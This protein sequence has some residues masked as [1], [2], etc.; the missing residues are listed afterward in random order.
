ML[1]L[2]HVGRFSPGGSTRHVHGQ[3]K[4]HDW[5][6]LGAPA[7]ADSTYIA[8]TSAIVSVNILVA[9]AD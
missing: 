4:N 8:K 2:Q 6:K 5:G 7:R 9:I 1:L 3:L